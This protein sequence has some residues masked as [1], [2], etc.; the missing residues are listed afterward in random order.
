LPPVAGPGAIGL[1]ASSCRFY[2]KRLV[3]LLTSGSMTLVGLAQRLM[4]QLAVSSSLTGPNGPGTADF[5]SNRV[6][7]AL[8]HLVDSSSTSSGHDGDAAG[9][10]ARACQRLRPAR[11][12][13]CASRRD[14]VEVREHLD[15]PAVDPE[16][17]PLR[18]HA[19]HRQS[20][21]GVGVGLFV[22]DRSD[23]ALL[24][25]VPQRLDTPPRV[26]SDP[27]SIAVCIASL[28]GQRFDQP[29]A[30]ATNAPAGISP[31]ARSC[32]SIRAMSTT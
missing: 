8:R 14:L 26:V 2:T 29:D 11:Q 30:N 15:L 6:D 12:D 17:I 5:R 24:D 21:P 1:E 19:S 18:I 31:Y 28:D 32:S 3:W 16:E 4:T 13:Q 10:E 23:P 25:Q 7:L 9:G 20:R 22:T 27:V